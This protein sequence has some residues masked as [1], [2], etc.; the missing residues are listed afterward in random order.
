MVCLKNS[1][2]QKTNLFAD[3]EAVKDASEQFLGADKAGDTA[4]MV[5]GL[6]QFLG[7][8]FGGR[9]LLGVGQGG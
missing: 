2:K 8:Y 9:G 7:T 1:I 3:A 4:D 6:A 5:A